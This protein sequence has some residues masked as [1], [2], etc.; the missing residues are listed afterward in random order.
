VTI[1]LALRR[2]EEYCE[3][4]YVQECRSS[5]IPTSVSAYVDGTLA[6]FGYWIDAINAMAGV[7]GPRHMR[8]IKFRRDPAYFDELLA[9]IGVTR[10]RLAGERVPPMLNETFTLKG[11]I[12][13]TYHRELSAELGYEVRERGLWDLVAA[14]ALRFADDRERFHLLGD[15]AA[16]ETAA[17]AVAVAE[18]R[19]F[20]P[21]L[22]FFAHEPPVSR[23][24]QATLDYAC[25]TAEDKLVIDAALVARWKRL[26][27]Q[28]VGGALEP[29]S[30]PRLGK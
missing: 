24:E 13:L 22:E 20:A 21:Y 3:S 12:A 11:E 16:R 27:A 25:L 1:V 6:S 23:G 17:A 9:A 8:I 15:A 18:E 5:G 4:V 19:G 30:V 14:R 2:I 10:E 26:G 7:I 29:E 28:P